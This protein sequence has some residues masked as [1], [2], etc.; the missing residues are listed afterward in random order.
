M[1]IIFGRAKIAK[2]I[3]FK[4]GIMTGRSVD[5]YHYATTQFNYILAFKVINIGALY[6]NICIIIICYMH[7]YDSLEKDNTWNLASLKINHSINVLFF[8][9]D[10]STKL[11]HNIS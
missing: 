11:F 9:L 3:I 10:Q 8:A 4:F 5:F 7:Y 2:F 1:T 6:I